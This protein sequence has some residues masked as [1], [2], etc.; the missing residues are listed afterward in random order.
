MLDY[1]IRGPLASSISPGFYGWT[2]RGVHLA[3]CTVDWEE[4][5]PNCLLQSM[6]TNDSDHRP[7][8]LGLKDNHS[9]RR[10]IHF[11]NFWPQMEGFQEAVEVAW[12]YVPTA[13]CPFST[14]DA[15]IKE[16]T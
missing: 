13:P 14:L 12:N 8:V 7:L 15:K 3:L 5:F 16:L 9:G 6:A 10:R 4:I 1:S 11:E 2:G